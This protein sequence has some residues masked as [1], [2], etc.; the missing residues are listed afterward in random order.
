M[1]IYLDCEGLRLNDRMD[2]RVHKKLEKFQRYFDDDAEARVKFRAEASQLR[3][4]ITLKI[5]RHYYRAEA[6]E[7]Q[8]DSAFDKT[9]TILEG[10]IRKHKTKMERKLR[11]YAYMKDYLREETLEEELGGEEEEEFK[12]RYKSFP[13]QPMSDEEAILQMELLG[14]NFFL[15]LN[16]EQGK[17]SLVYKRKEG[18]YGIIEP[19]Y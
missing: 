6:L 10:Q 13:I 14:H 7:Q 12:V 2:E 15:Y 3:C 5:D 17:V 4:E 18:S 1:K 11:N 8:S 19:E 9:L 16:P